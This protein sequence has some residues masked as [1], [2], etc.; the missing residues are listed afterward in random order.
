MRDSQRFGY[1]LIDRERKKENYGER[2]R[3]TEK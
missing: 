2:E 1:K 3:K